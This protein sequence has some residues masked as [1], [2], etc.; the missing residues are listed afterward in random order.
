MN[1]DI[2]D[3]LGTYDVVLL[4]EGGLSS[5]DANRVHSLHD[6]IADQV[7]YHVL[8]PMDHSAERVEA[9]MGALSTGDPLSVGIPPVDVDELASLE[10]E[11]RRKCEENLTRALTHL[12][13]TGAKAE[14]RVVSGDVIDALGSAVRQ[15]DTREVI[16]LTNPHVVAEFFHTDWTSKARRK[17]D[18]PV[19]HL[20]EHENFDQQ[21]E[22]YGEGVT[23]L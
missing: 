21:S 19:L 3:G 22:G 17:L 9:A 5:G 4:V 10:S 2:T 7:V 8:I 13:A 1:D 12:R 14:G 6:E 23:G 18:V 15:I 11:D 20:V 16:V